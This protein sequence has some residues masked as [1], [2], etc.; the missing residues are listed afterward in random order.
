[1][2]QARAKMIAGVSI[3]VPLFN[4]APYVASTLQGLIEQLCEA[5]EILVVD[6]QSSDG[7]AEI[8]RALL[9]GTANR[10]RV[11][12]L[13][14]NVGPAS[15]RNVGARQAKSSH[16]LFF[17]ADDIPSPNLLPALRGV[18]KQYSSVQVFAYQIAFQARGADIQRG[19]PLNQI[20]ASLRPPHA[21]AADYLKG[22]T[23]C[24]ASSTCV[25]RDAFFSTNGG[26]QA[27]L[28]FGEDPEFWARL[29]A[30][31]SVLEIHETLATYRDVKESLSHSLRGRLGSVN[32][33]VDSLQLLAK[34]HGRLYL[35]LARLMLFKNLVFS[36]ASGVSHAEASRQLSKYQHCLGRRKHLQL[37]CVNILP[38][39]IFRRAL[40][41]RT[42]TQI[43]MRSLESERDMATG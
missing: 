6:D 37:R 19:S 34:Q 16:L 40:E 31:Y 30:T 1:M 26:F 27:G 36:R 42:K 12:S 2:R 7:G 8:A 33:Y 14:E 43:Q 17:D 32:P 38:S 13:P 35:Q 3:I 15:A 39:V 10:G 29:S 20:T 11:I 28:R 21:F 41:F 22:K 4:K 23:L 25:T 24:T 5:D 9:N 18:I